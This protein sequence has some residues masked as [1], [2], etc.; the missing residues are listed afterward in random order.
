M[1]LFQSNEPQIHDVL[2]NSIFCV[3]VSRDLLPVMQSE[4]V[5]CDQENLVE[6]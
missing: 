2:Q 4:A 1:N 5:V 6:K 3:E